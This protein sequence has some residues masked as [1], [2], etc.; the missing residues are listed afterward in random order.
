MAQP[1]INATVALKPEGGPFTQKPGEG[2]YDIRTLHAP[3]LARHPGQQ[4]TVQFRYPQK[5]LRSPITREPRAL[6]SEH[7][8][9]C[10][11]FSGAECTMAGS[12]FPFPTEMVIL[13]AFV[14]K[15]FSGPGK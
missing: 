11:Q 1:S 4:W 6:P 12:F 15:S 13:V 5:E 7:P 9:Q 3:G 2:L 14:L 10:P 8:S